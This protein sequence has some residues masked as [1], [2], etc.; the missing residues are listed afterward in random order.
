M[1]KAVKTIFLL[2]PL[3]FLLFAPSAFSQSHHS[4]GTHSTKSHSS[5]SK[6]S[7]GDKSVHVKGYYRKDGT[8]VAAYD[9]SAP[10]SGSS[11]KTG[12]PSHSST[13]IAATYKK[14]HIAEGYTADS[15][16]QR[17]RHG[18]IKRSSSAKAAFERES[19]CPSTGKTSG[20]CPGY[21]VDHVRPLECG[22]ADAPSNMQWQTTAD[23]KAKDRTERSCRQ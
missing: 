11:E 21:V 18:K 2:Y 14:N 16:V 22:G 10:G 20:K 4:S 13:S 5:K 3:V 12:T 15:S 6:E 17:D 8:Y 23:A 1:R 7:K 9:R 19:P